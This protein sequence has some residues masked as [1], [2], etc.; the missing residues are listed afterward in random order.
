[1][2]SLA[3]LISL[4]PNASADLDTYFL[5]DADATKQDAAYTDV[6]RRTPTTETT[7]L[8]MQNT[9]K[10]QILGVKPI[11]NPEVETELIFGE[12]MVLGDQLYKSVTWTPCD[13]NYR[14]STR[15]YR[16]GTSSD[17]DVNLVLYRDSIDNWYSMTDAEWEAYEP[18]TADVG[19]PNCY[20]VND[21]IP[22]SQYVS[23]RCYI[24]IY[25]ENGGSDGSTSQYTT[26][27][28][29]F[30]RA[31]SGYKLKLTNFTGA[32]FNCV[33]WET[34]KDSDLA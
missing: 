12:Q 10:I 29:R 8:D 34:F 4:V 13:M 7:I 19:S 21:S 30:G 31:F 5:K 11:I 6:T 3:N 14:S 17:D 23:S 16:C 2:P 1:M 24:T 27:K 25:S 18:T 9:A 15:T 20:L 26:A 33:G 32:N 28:R 22:S